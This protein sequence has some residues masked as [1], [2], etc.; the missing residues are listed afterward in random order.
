[1]CGFFAIERSR[2][3]DVVRP[4]IGFKIAFEIIVRGRPALRVVEIPIVFR[5]RTRGQSKMSF[6][7]CVSIFLA[8][9]P[10]RLSAT[11]TK[12]AGCQFP[13]RIIGQVLASR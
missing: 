9:D 12:L 11:L 6:W 2:L 5:D 8:M 4:A 7:N 3:L 10:L 1:M 13:S